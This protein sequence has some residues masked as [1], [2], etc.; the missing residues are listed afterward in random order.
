[1]PENKIE[2]PKNLQWIKGDKIGNV[3]TVEKVDGDFTVFV[4]GGKIFTDVLEEFLQPIDDNLAGELMKTQSAPTQTQAPVPPP[5]EQPV[6]TETSALRTLLDK[7]KKLDKVPMGISFSV[8]IPKKKIIDVL[9]STFDPE[10]LHKELENFIEDQLDNE[11]IL[12]TVK[13]SI[14]ILIQEKYKGV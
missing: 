7:Q 4:G 10:E 13:D 5:K 11:V 1:M 14:K 8:N 6:K 12:N 9:E 3:E 2:E